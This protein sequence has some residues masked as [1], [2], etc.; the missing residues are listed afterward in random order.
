MIPKELTVDKKI[1]VRSYLDRNLTEL[2][3][4]TYLPQK[5]WFKP[6]T[7]PAAAVS[8]PYQK[9]K[10][11][12]YTLETKLVWKAFD[13]PELIG[14]F[15]HDECIRGN[16][17]TVYSPSFLQKAFEYTK[18]SQYW[19]SIGITKPF[20]D[21]HTLRASCWED[22]GLQTGTLVLS[23]AMRHA[24][25]DLERAVRREALGLEANYVWD[26]WCP[27]GFS[28]GAR[29]DYLPRFEYNPYRDPDG[30]VVTELDV[31]GFNTHEALKERYGHLIYP[32]ESA[33][34]GIFS[35]ISHGG[36]TI[37][38]VPR[39][40]AVELYRRFHPHGDGVPSTAG[41]RAISQADL[42]L[43]FY[44]SADPQWL[45]LVS[46]ET[47]WEGVREAM[48]GV[49]EQHDEK[50][51]AAR[52]L[53][54]TRDDVERVR[55]FFEEKCGWSKGFM[56]TPNKVITGAVM[57]YLRELQRLC[58]ETTWGRALAGCTTDIERIDVMG[59]DAFIVYK[60]IEDALLD[61]R[62]RAWASRFSG[63]A[64][65]ETTLDYLL[66]NFGRRTVNPK[67]VN[68]TGE[69]F[70]REQ[71]P[72]GRQVQRRVVSADKSNKLAEVRRSRGKMWSKKKS[73]FDSL[74]QKQ[75]QNFT[76][77]VH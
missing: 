11:R 53:H 27:I 33:F 67:N 16:K 7:T 54:H 12:L 70:D 41:G 51:E 10:Y 57:S 69:E 21:A 4:R 26:R 40:G 25:I 15:L 29:F 74:H 24:I 34:D 66:E 46:R 77:G 64:K 31:Q 23:Q 43:L 18:E 65:E 14:M 22:G 63:E 75:L 61:K 30:V 59:R 44:L 39:A 71:E 2:S 58:T 52:L 5:T 62:R 56:Y 3:G 32:D 8:R 13:T 36:L 72:I 17:E 20:Y 38:D 55:S 35:S 28:D 68:T 73:V 48:G 47:S 76:Y 19:R 37:E 1:A 42:R 50:I 45:E 9:E 60:L 6:Y 49:Q